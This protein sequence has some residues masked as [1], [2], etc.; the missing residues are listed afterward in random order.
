MLSL[1]EEGI[2]D[3]KSGVRGWEWPHGSTGIASLGDGYFYI[4]YHGTTPEG[5]SD[6][7]VKLCLFTGQPPLG[8][9]EV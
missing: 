6:S 8:F 4:G 3:E 1:A 5:L 7:N 2:Y 9:E